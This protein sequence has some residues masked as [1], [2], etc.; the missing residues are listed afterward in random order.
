MSNSFRFRQG[1]YLPPDYACQRSNQTKVVILPADNF[2]K[3]NVVN[4]HTKQNNI[5][6]SP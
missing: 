6:I 3:N 5:E 1:L 4:M 2:M